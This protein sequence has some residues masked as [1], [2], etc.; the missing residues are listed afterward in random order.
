MTREKFRFA[1]QTVKVRNEIPKFGGADFTI[2]D[3]WE[4]VN[5]G[6]SWMN[7]N[8]NPAA[9]MYAI[10]TGSQDFEV[11]IDN[12]VVYG[13]NRSVRTFIPRFRTGTSRKR[14]VKT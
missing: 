2:E 1:G 3:Y 12:E 6:T 8:G 4:N 10:R 5:G 7:S 13:K 11:P 14:S 9:M